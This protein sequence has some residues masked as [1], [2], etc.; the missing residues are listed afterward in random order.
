MQ[1]QEETSC[2]RCG[3]KRIFKRQWKEVFGRGPAI[4]HVETV[5]PDSE[6]Q[7]IVDAEFA[8]KRAKRLGLENRRS[9]I[10]I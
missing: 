2:I 1:A 7:K 8:E 4:I 3:K 6:C 5:C 9:N 10:K